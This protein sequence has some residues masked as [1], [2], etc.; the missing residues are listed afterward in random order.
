MP[1]TEAWGNQTDTRAG[2]RVEAMPPLGHAPDGSRLRGG[3]QRRPV[4]PYSTR[5][6][7]RASMRAARSAGISPA[8]T[9]TTTRTRAAPA[10]VDGS[11]GAT[12]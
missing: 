1:P 11:V 8:A 12:P 3:W 5:R 6:A 9:A 4:Y 10:M 2:A 7:D